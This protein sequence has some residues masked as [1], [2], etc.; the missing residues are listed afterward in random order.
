MRKLLFGCLGIIGVLLVILVIGIAGIY[1]N[2]NRQLNA[3][4]DR[5]VQ[6]ISV[7][8]SPER[9]ARGRYLVSTV[10]GC[11]G[12]H[13]SNRAS[14]PPLL[15][16]GVVEDAA[17]LGYFPAPNLTPGGKLKNYSDAEI[18]RSIT[19]GISK[20][21]R[22]LVVMPSENFKNLSMDD[23]SAIIAYL[24]SMPSVE[25]ELG[26][27]SLSP[28]GTILLGTGQ[29]PLSNQPPYQPKP[30]VPVGP[31]KEFGTYLVTIGGCRD[32]HGANLDG[33]DTTPGPPPGPDLAIVKGWTDQQFITTL[34]SGTDPAGRQLDPNK[35]PWKEFG[36]L[37]DSDLKAIYEYLKAR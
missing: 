18:A 34:R 2:A 3:T 30:G 1:F 35:M 15:D 25:R 27:V 21:G 16:G 4:I 19:E 7:Q 10:P 31:T 9:V 23:L 22:P 6:A 36:R 14:D 5:P 8:T 11:V 37:T 32:C 26:K 20:E 13:A 33:K 28:L 17:V 12:C 24:R 29:V